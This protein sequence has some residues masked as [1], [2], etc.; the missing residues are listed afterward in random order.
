MAFNVS[1]V[2]EWNIGA[3]EVAKITQSGLINPDFTRLEYIQNTIGYTTAINTKIPCN[4]NYT[5]TVKYKPI[6][7]NTGTQ[8]E[9]F[10]S[11]GY[12]KPIYQ[13]LVRGS[14]AFNGRYCFFA[15]AGDQWKYYNL[16][17]SLQLNTEVSVKLAPDGVYFNGSKIYNLSLTPYTVG[18]FNLFNTNALCYQVSTVQIQDQNLN[19]VF[20]GVPARRNSDLQC[21]LF[22]RVSQSF[23]YPSSN[24][25][26]ITGGEP[27][28]DTVIWSRTNPDK[29]AQFVSISSNG[30]PYCLLDDITLTANTA[31]EI[32]GK[33]F[34]NKDGGYRKIFGNTS[35]SFFGK[36]GSSKISWSFNGNTLDSTQSAYNL[37][38]STT[39][40][41]IPNVA[42]YWNGVA[43]QDLSN[44]TFAPDTSLPLYMFDYNPS[45]TGSEL[46]ASFELNHLKLYDGEQLTHYIIPAQDEVNNQ[47]GL[48]DI[49]TDKFYANVNTS[50]TAPFTIG[51]E[52]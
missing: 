30:N 50:V 1:D 17:N 26:Y 24:A 52:L 32:K 25:S 49:M 42:L 48:Y 28:L 21:G 11:T 46:R 3:G 33:W 14:S 37:P 6:A 22:D 7:Y 47:Y 27:Q 36:S 13:F 16:N 31:V 29:Y 19:D 4:T 5:Y 10:G 41:F 8:C 34:G 39:W 51:A 44:T 43:Y 38:E 45:T 40:K 18:T 12:T 9:I 20:F 35:L 15:G 23:F 2:K